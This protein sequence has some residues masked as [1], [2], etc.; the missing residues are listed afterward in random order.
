VI[1]DVGEEDEEFAVV[2]DDRVEHVGAI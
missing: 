2:V 1:F